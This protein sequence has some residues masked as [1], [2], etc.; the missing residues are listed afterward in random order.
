[1]LLFGFAALRQGRD[2]L[3]TRLPMQGALAAAYVLLA[4][5]QISQF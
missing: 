1:V 5:A 3:R 4:Q 2:W